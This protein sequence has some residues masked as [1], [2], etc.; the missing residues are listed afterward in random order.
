MEQIK[1][2]TYEHSHF[3]NRLNIKD[4]QRQ[5]RIALLNHSYCLPTGIIATVVEFHF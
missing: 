3:K 5:N 2:L 4:K 1:I